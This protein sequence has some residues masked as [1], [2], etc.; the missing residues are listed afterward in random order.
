MPK[1]QN[2]NM[3]LIL[4]HSERPKLYGVLAALSAI[5][6][7]SKEASL[8]H[9]VFFFSGSRILCRVVTMPPECGIPAC[10]DVSV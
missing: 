10:T 7:T 8:F 9:Y 2:L 5:G 3:S 4:L 6:L 1:P